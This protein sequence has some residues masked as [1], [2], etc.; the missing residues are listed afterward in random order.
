M[1]LR[2]MVKPT[3]ML[4]SFS[5]R[6]A[7]P[8]AMQRMAITSEAGVMLKPSW[9]GMPL[10]VPPSPMVMLRSARSFMSITRFQ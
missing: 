4:P 7:M 10:A 8:S 2:S 5:F 3:K 6:S 1:G 9:R